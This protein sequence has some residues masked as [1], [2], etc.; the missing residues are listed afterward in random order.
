LLLPY[1]STRWTAPVCPPSRWRPEPFLASAGRC[2]FA[3]LRACH[4][5]LL[6]RRGCRH[7]FAA[8]SSGP[9]SLQCQPHAAGLTSASESERTYSSG[10]GANW[11]REL[12]AWVLALWPCLPLDLVDESAATSVAA[13]WIH[14][15]VAAVARGESWGGEWGRVRGRRKGPVGAIGFWRNEV[16]RPINGFGLVVAQCLSLFGWWCWLAGLASP[17]ADTVNMNQLE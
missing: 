1:F 12:R 7:P 13:V 2:P 17:Y 14:S 11:P 16:D 15:A 5:S 10:A 4:G 3:G 8:L 6:L 9:R